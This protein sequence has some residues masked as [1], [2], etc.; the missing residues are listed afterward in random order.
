MLA[1]GLASVGACANALNLLADQHNDRA[2]TV[3]TAQLRT[4]V[5]TVQQHKEGARFVPIAIPSLV[6]SLR[7]AQVYSDRTGD[8]RLS[9]ELQKLRSELRPLSTR[10]SGA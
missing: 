5:T 3:L 4:S 6:D 9:G 1:N 8:Q 2:V 7:R 10:R